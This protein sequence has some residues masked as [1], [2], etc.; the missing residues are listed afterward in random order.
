MIVIWIQEVLCEHVD[1]VHA[2]YF[3]IFDAEFMLALCEF[4]PVVNS[5][6]YT[7]GHIRCSDISWRRIFAFPFV[8]AAASRSKAARARDGSGRRT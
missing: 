4:L 3:N 7:H 1:Q 2:L 5:G 8:I 6:S